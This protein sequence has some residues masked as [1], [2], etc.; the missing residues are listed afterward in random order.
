MLNALSLFA[1]I[2][3][4]ASRMIGVQRHFFTVKIRIGGFI[5]IV[6]LWA[7][8]FECFV[9]FRILFHV[10]ETFS[11]LYSVFACIVQIRICK[12]LVHP[13]SVRSHKCCIIRLEFASRHCHRCAQAPA[14]LIDGMSVHAPAVHAVRM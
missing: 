4:I 7:L 1:F 10:S 13:E 12:M 9:P 14:L 5:N 6:P 3:V 2:L 8:T 11:S